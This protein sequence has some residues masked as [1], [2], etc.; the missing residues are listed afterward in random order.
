MTK[1]KPEGLGNTLI[2]SKVLFL[3]GV[4]LACLALYLATL[5]IGAA[6]FITLG[7]AAALLFSG[8]HMI[9]TANRTFKKNH[10]EGELRQAFDVTRYEPGHCPWTDDALRALECF[11]SFDAFY[12]SDFL[13]A[14]YQGKPFTRSDLTLQE[15][16]EYEEEDEDG[17]KTTHTR[18]ASFFHGCVLTFLFAEAFE[19]EVRIVSKNF[20]GYE[21]AGRWDKVETELEAFN[22]RFRVGAKDPVHALKILTPQMILGIFSMHEAVQAP[23][24][25]I[26]KERRLHVFINSGR[27]AFELSGLRG[28]ERQMDLLR[29]DIGCITNFMDTMYFKKDAL[30]LKE[31]AE[32]LVRG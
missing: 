28:M 2:L 24:L 17:N 22:E 15:E 18:M 12:G 3:G 29:Q 19:S 30:S 11:K 9:R 10:V 13:E 14:A 31:A 1:E 32:N 4:G 16:E 6:L 5:G 25:A 8:V 7:L 26:F 23:L 20:D 21:S 27:D